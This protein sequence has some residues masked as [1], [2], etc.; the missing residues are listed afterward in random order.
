MKKTINIIVKIISV[1]IAF[2]LL[3][4]LF[5]PKYIEKNTDAE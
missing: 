2:S 1:L 3:T 4:M 5:M